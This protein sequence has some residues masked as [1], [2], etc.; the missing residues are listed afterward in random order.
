M[1]DMQKW[2]RRVICNDDGATAMADKFEERGFDFET[3]EAY[4][5]WARRITGNDEKALEVV[6]QFDEAGF[7]LDRASDMYTWARR[8]VGNDQKALDLVLEFDQKNVPDNYVKDQYTWARRIVGND[9]KALDM[10]R[11]TH[12]HPFGPMPLWY[13]EKMYKFAR[14]KTGNDDK[15]IDLIFEWYGLVEI[16]GGDGW[17]V[18]WQLP[19]FQELAEDIPKFYDEIR[20]HAGNDEEA[21]ELT[22]RLIKIAGRVDLAEFKSLWSSMRS[23][24]GNDP[25]CLEAV[26]VELEGR[27]PVSR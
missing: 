3:A 10:V 2:L 14:S 7:T 9:D 12:G 13:T 8:I 26:F 17:L 4:Y 22:T 21:I 19:S 15:A 1:S 25:E 24:I 5:D 16:E 20:R 6:F 27:D 23:D 18:W 11:K